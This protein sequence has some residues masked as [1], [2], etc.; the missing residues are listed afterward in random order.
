[1]IF[2]VL[3]LLSWT[4]ILYIKGKCFSQCKLKLSKVWW[5]FLQCIIAV[6][7]S[8]DST[9][10]CT[11]VNSAQLCSQ[12]CQKNYQLCINSAQ[13]CKLAQ[14]IHSWNTVVQ[15]WAELKHSWQPCRVY[16]SGV[17]S[18]HVEAPPSHTPSVGHHRVYRS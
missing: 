8:F 4:Y 6:E 15:T 13:V 2:D 12:L 16:C 11:T 9:L 14:F 7:V 3:M 10:G 18:S 5:F 1:M 17:L